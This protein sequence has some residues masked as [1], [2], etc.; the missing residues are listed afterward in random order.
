M[1]NLTEPSFT[2]G[3]R[4]DLADLISLIDAKDTPF[5]SMA[6]KGSET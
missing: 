6:K 5:T 1:A 2:S 4:E 3:K